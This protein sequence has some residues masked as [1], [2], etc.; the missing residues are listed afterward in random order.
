MKQF[1]PKDLPAVVLVQNKQQI[2]YTGV[3]EHQHLLKWL[4]RNIVSRCLEITSLKELTHRRSEE[5]ILFLFAQ[6]QPNE[7]ELAL[8]QRHFKQRDDAECAFTSNQEL[9]AVNLAG[10]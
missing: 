3:I 5:Q 10:C 7:G 8:Y 4:R 1:A 6:S 9:L 2:P